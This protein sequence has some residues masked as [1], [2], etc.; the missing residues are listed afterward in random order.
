[1]QTITIQ[2]DDQGAVTVTVEED[3]NA[4]DPVPCKSAAEAL[5]VVK[6]ALGEESA[7]PAGEQG[8]EPA[9]DYAAAWRDEA[10]KRQP[11]AFER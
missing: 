3:G 8:S 9:E 1:M 4:S 7:E 6:S 5:D 11:A 2:T 10:G